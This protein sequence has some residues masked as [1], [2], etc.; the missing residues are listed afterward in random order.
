[1]QYGEIEG[2]KA[3]LHELLR[4]MID[5]Y[6]AAHAGNAC[7]HEAEYYGYQARLKAGAYFTYGAIINLNGVT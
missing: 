7:W 5:L 1:M 2:R 4:R 3:T 6:K